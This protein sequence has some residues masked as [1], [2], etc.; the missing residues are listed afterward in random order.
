[1]LEKRLGKDR[2]VALLAKWRGEIVQHDEQELVVR[3][4]LSD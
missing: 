1:V 3:T 2:A 4:D